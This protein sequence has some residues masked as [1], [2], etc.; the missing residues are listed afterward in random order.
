LILGVSSTKLDQSQKQD[1]FWIS[2][3]FKVLVTL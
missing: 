2:V 1:M 3:V